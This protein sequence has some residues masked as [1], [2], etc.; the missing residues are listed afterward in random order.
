[1]RF[2]AQRNHRGM[3][4]SLEPQRDISH[5]NHETV[6]GANCP[7]TPGYDER[8][9]PRRTP[10]GGF[11]F[12]FPWPEIA[13]PCPARGPEAGCHPDGGFPC[14]CADT[15]HIF[16]PGEKTTSIKSSLQGPLAPPLLPQGFTVHAIPCDTLTPASGNTR[17]SSEWRHYNNGK[18]HRNF[19][20]KRNGFFRI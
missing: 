18:V 5:E 8:P 14:F 17:L 1:M 12:H 9:P 19:K 7:H 20:E 13:P 3:T 11:S 15:P 10:R 6:M 2:V 4:K 16:S